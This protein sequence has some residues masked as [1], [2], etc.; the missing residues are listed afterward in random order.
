LDTQQFD[1][2]IMGGGVAG[3]SAGTRAAELGLRTVIVEKGAQPD[4]PCNSRYSGRGVAGAHPQRDQEHRRSAP[5]HCTVHGGWWLHQLAA[6][7]GRALHAITVLQEAQCTHRHP[8]A[9]AGGRAGLEGPRP[10][11]IAAT[12]DSGVCCPG[13][14]PDA[15][16]RRHPPCHARR[17]LLRAGGAIRQPPSCSR[18]RPWCWPTAA[19]R[20]TSN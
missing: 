17:A 9:P 16:H 12:V 7:Q 15:G 13:R 19:S 11:C 3:L 20:P 18:P 1:V 2:V 6:G 10:R 5:V 4:Y 8:G 14:Q